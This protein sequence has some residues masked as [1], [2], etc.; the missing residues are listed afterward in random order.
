MT[1]ETRNTRVVAI[2]I[3]SMTVGAACLLWLEM[4]T[5]GWSPT[6]FLMAER[7]RPVED[8]L[9][10]YVGPEQP[11]NPADYDCA[12]YSDGRCDWR[13]RQPHIRLAVVGSGGER[14]GQAQA[15]S[16]LAALGSM[17]RLRGLDLSR[18]RLHADSDARVDSDAS[19]QA[20]DLR[21]LL[22]RKGIIP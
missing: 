16:L 13:P 14:L 15:G 2:L 3:V 17:S 22:V 8:V 11:F 9:I 4:P 21:D 1:G 10:E 7:G 5:R 18:V 12:V 19:P 20:R 6:T